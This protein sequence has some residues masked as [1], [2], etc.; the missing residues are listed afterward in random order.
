[1][2]RVVRGLLALSASPGG[3]TAS[4]LANHVVGQTALTGYCYGPRQASYDLKKLRGRQWCFG[5]GRP[6]GVEA[7][8]EALRTLNAVALLQNKVIRPVLASITGAATTNELDSSTALDER[9]QTLRKEMVLT[10][11]QLGFVAISY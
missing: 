7:S 3:F 9:Y 10:L 1:M 4:Q 5:S 11:R 6:G 8:P 2:Q